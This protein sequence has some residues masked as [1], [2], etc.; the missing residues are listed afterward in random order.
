MRKFQIGKIT[1]SKRSLEQ[2]MAI[3]II[4]LHDVLKSLTIFVKSPIL[5]NLTEF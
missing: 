5:D 4:S 2:L 1:Y 3:P